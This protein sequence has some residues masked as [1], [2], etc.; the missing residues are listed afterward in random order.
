MLPLA[1]SKDLK[2]KLI[3]L[4]TADLSD[5]VLRIL[6]EVTERNKSSSYRG[7]EKNLW[8]ILFFFQNQRE[9]KVQSIKAKTGKHLRDIL[10]L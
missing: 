3:F 6:K 5:T 7:E 9:G 8:E 1:V 2:L 10:R 4:S